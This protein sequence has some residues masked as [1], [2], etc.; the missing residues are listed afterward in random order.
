M[1]S[2]QNLFNMSFKCILRCF[3]DFEA[4]SM[5]RLFLVINPDN[6]RV[7]E[8]LLLPSLPRNSLQQVVGSLVRFMV[9][10]SMP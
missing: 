8:G 4:L 3:D 7:M 5:G 1:K 9:M 6:F 2:I 10:F